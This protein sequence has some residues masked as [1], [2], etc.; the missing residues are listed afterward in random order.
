MYE[1]DEVDNIEYSECIWPHQRHVGIQHV[2]G[3]AE[4]VVR[5]SDFRNK[6]FLYKSQV[7]LRHHSH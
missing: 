2:S 4:S 6:V 3:Y 5:W 1:A 7:M